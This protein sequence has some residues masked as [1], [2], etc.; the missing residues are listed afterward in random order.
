M[1][2]VMML[3]LGFFALDGFSYAPQGCGTVIA[4]GCVGA[5][6][7]PSY[8]SHTVTADDVNNTP[9]PNRARLS[10][11]HVSSSL[12]PTDEAVFSV[13]INRV[14]VWTGTL[15]VGQSHNFWADENDYVVVNASLQP[16]GSDVVCVWLGESTYSLC[17][18]N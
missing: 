8:V 18:D 13:I 5:C 7:S 10:V 9:N 6:G 15:N 17:L 2:S 14:I 11:T 12:C 3:L 4:T 16:T 1:A